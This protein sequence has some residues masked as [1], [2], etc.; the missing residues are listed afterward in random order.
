[1]PEKG[2]QT[3]G[4]YLQFK[5]QIHNVHRFNLGQGGRFLTFTFIS[6]CLEV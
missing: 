4:S 1:M 6:K 2:Q 3:P 5:K